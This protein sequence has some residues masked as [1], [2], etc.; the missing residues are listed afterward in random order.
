MESVLAPA[1]QAKQRYTDNAAQWQRALN[2]LDLD[3]YVPPHEPWWRRLLCGPAAQRIV[4]RS[5]RSLLIMH[6][7]RWPLRRILLI[8][9]ADPSD[10]NTVPWI[11]RLAQ[12]DHTTLTLLP[13]V[14][15]WPRLHQRLAATQPS[16]AVLLAPNTVSGAMIRQL[17]TYCRQHRIAT[18]LALT[19]GEPDT[20]IRTAVATHDPDLILIAAEPHSRLLR[21]FYG[22][23]VKPLLWWVKQPLL[24]AK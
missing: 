10:W 18:N 22:E 3:L 2:V 13:V 24:I 11:E 4:A 15:P 7:G 1:G 14:P 5:T 19:T 9:R 6:H 17:T 16:P 20:R 23:L 21:L 12:P 8:L